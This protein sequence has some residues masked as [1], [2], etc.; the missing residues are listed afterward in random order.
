MGHEYRPGDE[1]S[2]VTEFMRVLGDSR[3][4]KYKLLDRP[5]KTDREAPAV[6]FRFTD[7]RTGKVVAVEHT[8]FVRPDELVASKLLSGGTTPR[9]PDNARLKKQ[10]IDSMTIN[11]QSVVPMAHTVSLDANQWEVVRNAILSKLSKRQL[12]STEAD[13]RIL[14]VEDS[15]VS[16]PDRRMANVEI[17]FATIERDAIHGCYIILDQKSVRRFW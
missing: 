12:Q 8:Q 6:D 1:T 5:D 7:M 16:F 15:S 10:G 11:P 9:I 3:C 4:T 14:L 17:E 2:A 13:E